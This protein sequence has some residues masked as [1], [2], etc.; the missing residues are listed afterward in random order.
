MKTL[1]RILGIA[2]ILG[3]APA[4]AQELNCNVVINT[5]AVQS[6]DRRVFTEMKRSIQDFMNLRTWTGDKFT[7]EER[8]TCNL[9][10]TITKANS[11]TNFEATVQVQSSRPVYGTNYDTPL[12]NYVDKDWEFDYVEGQPMDFNTNQYFTNLTSLLGFYAY[13][14]IGLDYDT[15]SKLGGKQYYNF[16]NIIATNAATGGRKGWQSF[17]GTRNRYWLMENIMSQNLIAFR[18]A[19]Y[20]YH[21][22]GLDVMLDKPEETRKKALEMLKKIQTVLQVKPICILINNF[23][24]AKSAELISLFKEGAPGEKQA[25]YNILSQAD[26]TKTEQYGVL[27][28]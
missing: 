18:E 3:L 13:M 14:I 2:W 8:I 22:H 24:D 5:E 11:V 19:L 23:F 9:I 17:E 10:I 15:Y 28:K 27:I 21:R 4:L 6:I 26:P 1:F 16:C 12:L 25:A 7:N 20:D